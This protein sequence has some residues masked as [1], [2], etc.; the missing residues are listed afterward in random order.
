MPV[1]HLFSEEQGNSIL[2]TLSNLDKPRPKEYKKWTFTLGGIT[3]GTIEESWHPYAGRTV[4]IVEKWESKSKYQWTYEE[5]ESALFQGV[6]PETRNIIEKKE[7][8]LT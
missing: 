8:V 2:D 7:E 6:S 1:H 3:L 5:A 4:H